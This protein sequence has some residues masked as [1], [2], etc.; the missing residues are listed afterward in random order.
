[1]VRPDSPVAFFRWHAATEQHLAQSGLPFTILRPNFFMQNTFGFAPTITKEGKFYGSVKNGK[2]AMIDVRDIAVVSVRLLTQTGH[3]GK[4]YGITGPESL[5]MAD[6]AAKL[7]AALG[8]P[9]AYVDIPAEALRAN[10][11]STG[12]PDWAAEAIAAMHG[13]LAQ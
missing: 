10:L 5:S 7:S 11:L 8:K 3:E 1:A 6:A 4:T 9:V 2:I 12:V 13:V